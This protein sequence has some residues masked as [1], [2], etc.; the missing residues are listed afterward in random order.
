VRAFRVIIAVYL[1]AAVAL[2]AAASSYAGPPTWA[3]TGPPENAIALK[4]FPFNTK[5]GPP[6]VPPGL[7]RSKKAKDGSEYLIVKFSDRFNKGARER[8][9]A[10]GVRFYGYI[11]VNGFLAKVPPGKRHDV[12]SDQSVVFVGDYLPAYR[13]S[14][15][16]LGWLSR[17][18]KGTKALRV[19]LFDDE[20]VAPVVDAIKSLGGSAEVYSDRPG[21]NGKFLNVHIGVSGIS[22]LAALPGV[23]WMEP[24]PVLALFN[25]V[26]A[27]VTNVAAAWALPSPLKGTGQVVAVCDTGLDTGNTSTIHPDF[28]GTTSGGLPKIKATFNYGRFNSWSDPNG[29]GTHTCGSVLGAGVESNVL[30]PG[31]YIRG[32]AYDAQLVMQ[33]VLTNSGGLSIPSLSGTAFPDAYAQGARV[34]SNSWGDSLAS[35]HTLYT[36]MCVDA[37]TYMWNHKDFLAVFS[38]GNDGV[39]SS[40]SDG[41]VDLSSVS[42]PATAKNVL[43][44]GA[45]ENNRPNLISSYGANWPSDFPTDPINSDNMGDSTGGMVA[46]SSRGPCVDGRIKPDIVAPGTWVLSTKSSKA[47]SNSYWSSA[48]AIGYS[49]SLDN[50]Y[51]TDGGT[52]MSTPQVSG[53]CALVRQ[54]LIENGSPSPSA[55][56]VKTLLIE[57]A[58]D[59]TPGQYAPPNNDVTA[60]PDMNQGWGRLDMKG[61]LFPDA[62]TVVKYTD[63]QQGL[64]VDNSKVYEYG[65]ADV[66]VPLR[67]NLVWTDAPGTTSAGGGLVDDLDL[68]VTTPD[69]TVYHGN[70]YTGSA[71]TPNDPV[72]DG[73][74][75]VEGVTVP[76]SSLTTGMLDI[77]VYAASINNTDYLP[78]PYALVVTGGLGNPPTV[79]AILPDSGMNYGPTDVTVSGTDFADGCTLKVGTT[80]CTVNTVTPTSIDAVV[81]SGITPGTYDVTVTNP[82]SLS[83]TLTQGFTVTQDTTPPSAPQGLAASPGDGSVNLEWEKGAEPDLS[84]YHVYFN[85]YS[86]TVGIVD[87]Y[88]LTSL[89]NGMSYDISLKAEDAAGNLSASSASVSATPFATVSELPHYNWDLS[90][91]WGCTPCHLT[92]SGGILPQGFDYHYD[93]SLCLSCHNTASVGHDTPIMSGRSHAVMA[94]V[95]SG[96]ASMPVFGSVTSGEYSDTMYT[97]LK[98]GATIVCVTCHNPMRKPHDSGRTWELLYSGDNVNFSS[99]LGGWWD[100]GH[101]RLSAYRYHSFG[102]PTN[103]KE[104]GAY[105]V[106]ASEFS[107]DE[108]AGTLT[109]TNATSGYAYLTLSDPYLRAPGY[110]NTFCLDCHPQ[111]AT[112]R[113]Y[114]CLSCHSAHDETGLKLVRKSVRRPDGTDA[115][116]V[117]T[118]VT[119]AGSFA[120]GDNVY[121][122]IC[123]V[124]HTKTAYYRYDGSTLNNHTSTG[125]DYSGKDCTLCHS[126]A[127]GFEP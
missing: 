93:Q 72:F 32:M 66:S 84:G 95:T 74:N 104:R 13:L 62:P 71:S 86:T 48:S 3:R 38:A 94:N 102:T 126:H 77:T 70:R 103:V 11:P 29:H 35:D 53:A 91:A 28:A 60:R 125:L 110:D 111:K 88:R 45:S 5:T 65:I 44:V 51:A 106:P 14:S 23:L 109:F 50:Y 121:D 83:G 4:N 79:T 80:P 58:H 26:A 117:F 34:H 99:S 52:S 12:E 55:A 85:S 98:G 19:Q 81:P 118:N 100:Q 7:S 113:H 92:S 75:N 78:Q 10:A 47:S 24:E 22:A 15:A 119:G 89:T 36:S 124:C 115:D 108:L 64:Y 33:S 90:S 42:P 123:E 43:T 41:V 2:F 87:T 25:D 6:S 37:D 20:P 9:S 21:L 112:H 97:H 17:G 30:V 61:S 122:G 49:S 69:G 116:V 31:L 127:A 105:G 39:D 76:A 120:D 67:V 16:P 57:G 40:P 56:L 96:G 101:T 46:F 114:N 27:P 82:D 1:A 63:D 18:E 107:Y 8:L 59:M 73:V 68:I 54:Y